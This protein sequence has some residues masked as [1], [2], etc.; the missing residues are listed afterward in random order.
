MS[1]LFVSLSSLKQKGDSAVTLSFRLNTE[2]YCEYNGG[3][4]PHLE[5]RSFDIFGL[6]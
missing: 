3:R 1:L 2:F 4:I 5:C 6:S